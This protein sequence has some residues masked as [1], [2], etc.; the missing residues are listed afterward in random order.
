MIISFGLTPESISLR[1]IAEARWK[2]YKSESEKDNALAKDIQRKE[3]SKKKTER[4]NKM[5]EASDP[6]AGTALPY[7]SG[8]APVKENDQELDKQINSVLQDWIISS[9]D[10]KEKRSSALQKLLQLNIPKEYKQVPSNTMFRIIRAE[11]G[12]TKINLD[13][14]PYSSY[15]YDYKGVK[16]ILNWYKKDYND[17]L[18]SYLVEVPV[19]DVVISIPTFYKKTK[20]WNGKYFDQLV[21]TEYEVIAKNPLGEY[22]TEIISEIKSDPFGLNELA[23]QFVNETLIETWNPEESFVSLSRYMIDNFD[24][25]ENDLPYILNGGHY[26]KNWVDNTLRSMR[27]GIYLGKKTKSEEEGF[28]MTEE[29]KAQLLSEVQKFNPKG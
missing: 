23:R 3:M 25:H 16:K 26:V 5:K 15:A 11:P 24:G 28:G 14:T 7:G 17:N 20:I 27:D 22:E 6:Q 12:L 10:D 2:L 9:L 29:E 8:F 1:T 13:K 21:K 4:L 18:V 19:Q